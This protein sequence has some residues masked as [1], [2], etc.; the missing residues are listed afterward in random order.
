MRHFIAT[1]SD[2]IHSIGYDYD[3]CIMQVVFSNVPD[4]VYTYRD[5]QP[6]TY[7]RLMSAESLGQTFHNM[8]KLHPKV[9]PYTKSIIT[10]EL[11]TLLFKKG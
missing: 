1:N 7:A 11:Q 3:S 6:G 10:S 8:I 2:M 9:F 5:V 4:V